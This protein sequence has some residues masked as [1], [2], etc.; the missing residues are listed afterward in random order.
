MQ[1]YF[2]HPQRGFRVPILHM[3]PS[4]MIK[5]G[6]NVFTVNKISSEKGEINF[7]FVKRLHKLQDEEEFKLANRLSSTHINF[8][9]SKMNLR[10]ATQVLNSSVADAI[11]FLR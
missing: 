1:P 9:R 10:L 2:N 7:E 8:S 5:L 3:D 6:Q 4:D 11:I